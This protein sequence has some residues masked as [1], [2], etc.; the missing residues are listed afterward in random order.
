[1]PFRCVQR[2]NKTRIGSLYVVSAAEA[3]R[4]RCAGQLIILESTTCRGLPGGCTADSGAVRA[5]VGGFWP[6]F[7]PERVDPA[8]RRGGRNTPKVI[9]G[10]T[11]CM[12][13]LGLAF[14]R[15]LFDTMVPVESPEAAELVRSTR[16]RSG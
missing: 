11:R 3:V 10:I 6:V 12:W 8:A 7:Q 13:E 2:L 14:Y 9:G 4:H 16:T 15:R 1:M 5:D